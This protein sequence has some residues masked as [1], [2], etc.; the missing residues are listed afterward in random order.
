MKLH[1]LILSGFL[2]LAVAAVPAV[3]SAAPK[4][5]AAGSGDVL[6]QLKD[7]QERATDA[8]NR[9][10]ELQAVARDSG[11][12]WQIHA[13]KLEYLK[14]DI[15]D[16]GGRLAALEKVRDSASAWEK[17]AIDEA[18]PVLKQMAENTQSA[19]LF[20]SENQM[21]LF[22]PAYEKYVNNLADE[23]ERLSAS[24]NRYVQFATI[25]NKENRL[26]RTLGISGGSF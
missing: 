25:H 14:E 1:S 2:T 10:D 12:D 3:S 15:N 18:L 19:I 17:K 5:A 13:S 20:V 4:S 26:E 8:A 11:S 22:L 9:A 21:R 6:Q 23:S 7:L 16:M 24:L